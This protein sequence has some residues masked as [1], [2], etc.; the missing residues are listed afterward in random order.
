MTVSEPVE[1]APETATFAHVSR[2]YYPTI[3]ALFTAV[4]LI[5][6]ICATKG[7][8]FFAGS[9]LSIG[10]LQILPIITDGGFFLFPL[11]YVLGDVLSEVYGFK[12]TRRAIYLGFGALIL[13]A[14]CFWLLLALPSADF[15]EHQAALESVVGV[16][17]RLLLAGLSG[18]LVG[19]LLNSLVMVA[20]KERTKEKHLWARLIGSTVVGEFADTLIFCS[21]AAGAIGITTGGDFVNYLIVG[22]VWKILVEVLVMPITYRVIAYIKKR[23]PT[24][25]LAA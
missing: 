1:T 11:A 19:Q 15:Y 25:V 5:S 9:E 2:G 10:P 17:P 20:I 7:V 3:V 8:A 14:G 23:E 12:A 4:L 21:I 13:A 24:Y 16:Y 6:N 22:V 18:Y